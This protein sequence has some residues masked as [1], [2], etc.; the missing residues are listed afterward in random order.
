MALSAELLVLGGAGRRRRG[1]PGQGRPGWLDDGSA[2]ERFEPDGGGAGAGPTD[3]V[4]GTLEDPTCRQKTRRVQREVM[5]REAGVI[6]GDR[7]PAPFGLAVIGLGGRP[8]GTGRFD[9]SLCRVRRGRRDSASGSAPAA[10]HPAIVPR[11]HRGRRRARGR[12]PA[13]GG[14]RFPTPRPGRVPRVA[15]RG[16]CRQRRRGDREQRAGVGTGAAATP[17]KRRRPAG[18]VAGP[19][20][21]GRRRPTWPRSA[22]MSWPWR[23]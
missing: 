3:F 20:R 2:A 17:A 22:P 6:S 5:A 13:R 1:G 9:R 10:R 14:G 12:M 21:R 19:G 16:R 23:F 18:A 11:P 15:A 7:T 8:A 4:G